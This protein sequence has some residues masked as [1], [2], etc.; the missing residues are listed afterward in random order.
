MLVCDLQESHKTLNREV[1]NLQHELE[2][3]QKEIEALEG[4]RNQLE[5]E[6][7]QLEEMKGLVEDEKELLEGEL[8]QI[9][10]K[11]TEDNDDWKKILEIV[12]EGLV[13]A[14]RMKYLDLAAVPTLSEEAVNA[15]NSVLTTI[16]QIKNTQTP[17]E[18]DV[19]KDSDR[20]SLLD[21]EDNNEEE[22]TAF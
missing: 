7:Q 17:V 4:E 21:V 19:D 16:T 15:V 3:S 20:D 18:Y 10:E 1:K 22:F 8:D 5:E 9:A 14:S 11:T 2:N 12:R 6:K 13:G